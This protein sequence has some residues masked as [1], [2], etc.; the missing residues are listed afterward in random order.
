ME[1]CKAMEFGKSSRD[2]CVKHGRSTSP[3]K[4]HAA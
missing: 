4:T 1:T 3:S 2:S